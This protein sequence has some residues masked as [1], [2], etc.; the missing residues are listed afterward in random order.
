MDDAHNSCIRFASFDGLVGA[1]AAQCVQSA[2]SAG[3]NSA[4]DNGDGRGIHRHRGVA[5]LNAWACGFRSTPG[6][7]A[8][9]DA[10]PDHSD[11]NGDDSARAYIGPHQRARRLP[12]PDRHSHA[13]AAANACNHPHRGAH[14]QLVRTTNHAEHL[15]FC[16]FPE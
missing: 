7:A 3:D 6:D 11:A 15:P 16:G 12:H 14:G 5:K 1:V 4:S 13:C 8:E 9:R 10:D 2:N